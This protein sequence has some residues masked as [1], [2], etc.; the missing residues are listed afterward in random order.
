MARRWAANSALIVYVV[1]DEE[2]VRDLLTRVLGRNSFDVRCFATADDARTALVRA[3]LTREPVDVLLLD[4]ALEPGSEDT[5]S[6]ED[7]LRMVT[8]RQP[9]PE[10]VLMSGHLSSDEFFDFIMRGATDFVAKPWGIEELLQRVRACGHTGRQKYLHHY[11]LGATSSRVQRDAFLSYS[12][13]NTELALGLKRVLERMGIST[14]YAPADLPL[15]DHWADTLDAAIH[16]CSVFL[17]VLTADALDSEQ[18]M[19][20]VR[21]ALARR[22]AERDRFLVVPIAFGVPLASLPERLRTLQAVDLTNQHGF[23]DDIIR[24]A[25]RIS[26]F[27]ES[28]V[29]SGE[30]ERRRADRRGPA[31]RRRLRAS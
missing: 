21:R 17:V 20:E 16:G 31:E 10:V 15:G 12:S 25:D 4:M 28:R 30:L 6:A 23:V 7:L 1:D 2:P 26:Q 9:G 13:K 8:Q 19:S 5:R 22:E 11:S 14:W 27:V 18:V 3:G 29:A 24:L